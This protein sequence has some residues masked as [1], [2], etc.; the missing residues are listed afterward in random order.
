[1]KKVGKVIILTWQNHRSTRCRDR[2]PGGPL[3]GAL[4]EIKRSR[5][6]TPTVATPQ[7]EGRRFSNYPPFREPLLLGIRETSL[8][9]SGHTSGLRLLQHCE[10]RPK[11][12]NAVL[13][14]L[15]LPLSR[16]N[17]EKS[18]DI[19]GPIQGA[20][21]IGATIKFIGA[22]IGHLRNARGVALKT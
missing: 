12:N 17:S 6:W 2:D 3:R 4:R 15:S 16:R 19:P 18:P 9:A 11:N 20:A 21:G 8:T 14:L 22:L 7:K 5:T 10:A 1:V 13:K